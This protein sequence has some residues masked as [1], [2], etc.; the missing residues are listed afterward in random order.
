MANAPTLSN[1]IS[2]HDVGKSIADEGH[3]PLLRNELLFISTSMDHATSTDTTILCETY[4]IKTVISTDAWKHKRYIVDTK[5]S[6][7]HVREVF[8]VEN[9]L[10]LSSVR[11]NLRGDTFLKNIINGLPRSAKL[12]YEADA[13]TK[14]IRDPSMLQQSRDLV[15][16]RD[17]LDDIFLVLV[18]SATLIGKCFNNV[19][20]KEDMYPLIISG[21]RAMRDNTLIVFL[22]LLM[23]DIPVS[24]MDRAYLQMT[25]RL[26]L[27]LADGSD[28]DW[29]HRLR[30]AGWGKNRSIW[31]RELCR[32]ID[33]KYGSASKLF[34][35]MGVTAETID[36]IKSIM[37]APKTTNLIDF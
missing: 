11:I 35:V 7:R 30:N 25:N 4:Q 31:T 13:R 29:A 16:N 9:V 17:S 27:D 33:T 6:G 15:W 21:D 19:L 2:L 23:L 22:L 5:A 10:G 32:R 14:N 26:P 20:A 3:V 1:K 28:A 36:G 34:T 8:A 24:S 18:S 37:L 12:R